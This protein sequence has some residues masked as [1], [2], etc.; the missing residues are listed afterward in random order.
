MNRILMS[1]LALLAVSS[2]QA[3]NFAI[4]GSVE[5]ALKT[6]AA[7]VTSIGASKSDRSVLNFTANESLGNGLSVDVLMQA[8]FLSDTG[9]FNNTS[10][11]SLTTTE[12]FEQTRMTLNSQK[13]GAVRMGRFTNALARS[14]TP[15]LFQEDSPFGTSHTTQY[16]RLSG[17]REYT[18]P[19]FMGFKYNWLRADAASNK[20]ISF[21]SGNGTLTTTDISTG[22]R[23]LTAHVITYDKGPVA[24]SW[25]TVSGFAGESSKRYGGSFD[26]SALGV[27]GVKLAAGRFNQEQTWQ[28]QY[29]HKNTYVGA[30]Y[31]TGN[32]TTA[33]TASVADND[34]SSTT[35][36]VGK[37]GV[38]VYYALSKRT[39]LQAE[40][41]DTRNSTAALNGAT[42]YV[43]MRHTF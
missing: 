32:W 12:A 19:E 11:T 26:L 22:A 17:Q 31:R 4:S 39:T 20:Y 27:Q 40:W 29:P 30:E 8:R 21:V 35:G 43:G 1:I 10:S 36:K 13:F 16:S 3:Q 7:G 14:E 28:L 37:N 6:T 2:A 38:K 15:W 18:T 41:M 34:T 24:A 5:M 23:D 25:A 33:V 42:Y 9:A